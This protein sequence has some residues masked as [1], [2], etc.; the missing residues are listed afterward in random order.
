MNKNSFKFYALFFF[1]L[2]AITGHATQQ[3][4]HGAQINYQLLGHYD[5]PMASRIK[6]GCSIDQD[7][8]TYS[9]DFIPYHCT[10][11]KWDTAEFLPA[12]E[13]TQTTVEAARE[14]LGHNRF[15][16]FV[17]DCK[18]LFEGELSLKDK[19]ALFIL[20]QSVHHEMNCLLKDIEGRVEEDSMI[21]DEQFSF[22]FD[23]CTRS[24][25]SSEGSAASVTTD[26]GLTHESASRE[27]GENTPPIKEDAEVAFSS[28]KLEGI[29]LGESSFSS[30]TKQ[31]L[32][33][34]SPVCL[35]CD[36]KTI[37]KARMDDLITAIED[38]D[39]KTSLREIIFTN[40]S[41]IKFNMLFEFLR[42]F[43]A[44]RTPEN[45]ITI[46]YSTTSDSQKAYKKLSSLMGVIH[47]TPEITGIDDADLESIQSKSI[48]DCQRFRSDFS[49]ASLKS[50]QR[51]LK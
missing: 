1:I 11:I 12:F 23:C 13:K 9:L 50:I 16:T 6:G 15:Q 48:H 40:G 47:A 37:T 18:K 46:I 2:S 3:N 8:I 29:S 24:R 28:I 33:V 30:Y 32:K 20:M 49:E 39:Q 10:S 7:E 22:L 14:K 21:P 31:L 35:T 44:K 25:S 36:L 19:Y 27:S 34:N 26:N 51:V 43:S 38:I 5:K 4:S 45:P 41:S 17:Q 42:D